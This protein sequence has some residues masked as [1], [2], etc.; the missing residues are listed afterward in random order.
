MYCT[1][2]ILPLLVTTTF[3]P[4]AK[5]PFDPFLLG[6][7]PLRTGVIPL[8]GAAPRLVGVLEVER[9]LAA[10]LGLEPAADDGRETGR[11]VWYERRQKEGD[12]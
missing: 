1:T 7:E 9:E 4:I 2:P 11:P 6:V 12:V 5:P 10:E 8:L 3:A